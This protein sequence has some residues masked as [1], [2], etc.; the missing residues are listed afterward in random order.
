M[1]AEVGISTGHRY[2]RN[3]KSGHYGHLQY[4]TWGEKYSWTK[5][6]TSANRCGK[7]KLG[8]GTV[9]LPTK[10]VG[11]RYWETRT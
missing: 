1:I 11:W 3:I 5:Y 9:K 8:S 2:S 7:K 6:E 4:G 10:E